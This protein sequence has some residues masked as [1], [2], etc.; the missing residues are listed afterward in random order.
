[1]GMEDKNIEDV[2]G[3]VGLENVGTQPVSTFSLGMRQRLGIARAFVHKPELLI[4]D[5][6]VN[7]LDPIGMKEMRELFL[8]LS[9][10]E[11]ITILLSSHILSEIGQIADK[12]GFIVDG[13][14]EQEVSPEKIKRNYQNGLE[15][16][17]MQ[18]VNGGNADEKTNSI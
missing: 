9:K 11:G 7:G 5:E 3:M 18:I 6:P 10:Q 12:V 17:F 4:L 15:E 1:M 13:I 14:I 8:R 16:Y 2:L